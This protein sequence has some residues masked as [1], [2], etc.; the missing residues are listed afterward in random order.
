MAA[1]KPTKAKAE[2]TKKALNKSD[3]PK[4]AIET[5]K[6]SEKKATSKNSTKARSI[7]AEERYK[8]IEIAAYYIAEKNGFK[9]SSIDYWIAAEAEITDKIGKK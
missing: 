3:S 8:M 4:K 5:K 7:G 1:A 9:G 2:P 6:V